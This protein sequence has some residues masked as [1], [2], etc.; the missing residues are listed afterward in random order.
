ML[1]YVKK[2]L[3]LHLK[4][5]SWYKGKIHG[6]MTFFDMFRANPSVNPSETSNKRMHSQMQESLGPDLVMLAFHKQWIL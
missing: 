3:P 4:E 1:P 5:K 6:R 2:N